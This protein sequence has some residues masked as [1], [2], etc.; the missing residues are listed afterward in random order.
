MRV[1]RVVLDT[2]VLISAALSSLGKP[3]ASLAWVRRNAVLVSS[4]QLVEE[5]RTRLARPKFAKYLAPDEIAA[6]LAILSQEA[7]LVD[8]TGE[9][10]A[11]RDPDDDMV[12]E[13]AVK[14]KAGC[15][16]TGDKDLLVLDPFGD[17]RIVAPAA[18]LDAVTLD[19]GS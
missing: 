9:L 3:F 6:F 16:V 11:C 18:F 7:E 17:V 5:V 15:I 19:G 14:G 12:L 8:I 2:N 13:T 1:D 4:L 10:K